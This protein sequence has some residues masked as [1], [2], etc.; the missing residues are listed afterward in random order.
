[1]G[2]NPG[3]LLRSSP[4]YQEIINYY[5]LTNFLHKFAKMA[6]AQLANNGYRIAKSWQYQDSNPLPDVNNSSDNNTPLNNNTLRP[7]LM[8]NYPPIQTQAKQFLHA[9]FAKFCQN[10]A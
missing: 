6:T 2:L 10:P 1:M 4:L 7:I 8:A 9:N 3:Y 5:N